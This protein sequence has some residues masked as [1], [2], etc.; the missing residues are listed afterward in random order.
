MPRLCVPHMT[1][2]LLQPT[3][4]SLPGLLKML[5]ADQYS[6]S[7]AAA[8]NHLPALLQSEHEMQLQQSSFPKTTFYYEGIEALS[9]ISLWRQSCS[10]ESPAI[11]GVCIVLQVH[12]Q[13]M[14]MHSTV[15]AFCCHA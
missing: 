12:V 11:I 6:P 9:C 8:T 5:L 1:P 7:D 2:A 15:N 13:Y 3:Y 4:Y 14:Q 10:I